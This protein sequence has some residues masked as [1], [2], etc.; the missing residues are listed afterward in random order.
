MN[1]QVISVTLNRR[2]LINISALSIIFYFILC[3]IIHAAA[4][5]VYERIGAVSANV[6]APTNVAL[7]RYECVFVA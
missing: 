6:N 7:D 5:P 3:G 4:M 1:Q 2:K